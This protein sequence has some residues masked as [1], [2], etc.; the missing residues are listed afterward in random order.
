LVAIQQAHLDTVQLSTD[1]AVDLAKQ[2]QVQ[3]ATGTKAQQD[4]AAA[5]VALVTGQ[6]AKAVA[7]A[8]AGVQDATNNANAL[9]WKAQEALNKA[10]IIATEAENRAQAQLNE[11]Q[12]TASL[13]LAN[14]NQALAQITNTA[15]LAEATIAAQITV[16]QAQASTQ[17]AGS[18]L[19]VN[20]YGV[21]MNNAPQVV[22]E[23]SWALRNQLL[24]I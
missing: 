22:G 18:G 1:V 4:A 11:A 12:G 7:D 8:N 13:T 10:Q 20:Q 15:N 17:Y 23:L 14:A 2:Y 24:P 16:T 6:Q 19:V 21:D 5:Q 9:L 3:A